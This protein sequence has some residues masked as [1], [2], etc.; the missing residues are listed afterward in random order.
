METR[1]AGRREERQNNTPL[2][3]AEK[4]NMLE[5]THSISRSEKRL[6]AAKR[7]E[8]EMKIERQIWAFVPAFQTGA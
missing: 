2:L 4:E 7:E 1:G 8:T 6:P 5:L 3:V